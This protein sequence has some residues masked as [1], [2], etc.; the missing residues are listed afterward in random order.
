MNFANQLQFEGLIEPIAR[1]L[2]GKPNK[3]ESRK[4]RV[5]QPEWL[6]NIVD[7]LWGPA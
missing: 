3:R 6:H 4:P 7:R 1:R 5:R 2:L